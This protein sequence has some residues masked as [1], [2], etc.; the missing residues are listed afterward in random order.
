MAARDF[1]SLANDGRTNE[2]APALNED[3]DETT[4][5]SPRGSVGSTCGQNTGD[6]ISGPSSRK[7]ALR[8]DEAPS[9]ATPFEAKAT[10]SEGVKQ[11]IERKE[12]ATTKK[13][14]SDQS[15]L[16]GQGDGFHGVPEA[17]DNKE[18]KEQV[19][20]DDE[21][22]EDASGQYQLVKK[23]I[24]KPPKKGSIL[25]RLAGI[26]GGGSKAK[27][28][29]PLRD[30]DAALAARLDGPGEERD[31]CGVGTASTGGGSKLED[32][33]LD[34]LTDVDDTNS[35]I[36]VEEEEVEPIDVAIDRSLDERRADQSA[37]EARNLPSPVKSPQRQQHDQEEAHEYEEVPFNTE[38]VALQ[39]P[40]QVVIHSGE[41]DSETG[42]ATLNPVIAARRKLHGPARFATVASA[43]ASPFLVEI[44]STT[45]SGEHA[46]GSAAVA[47]SSLLVINALGASG[48]LKVEK[49]GT[50][51]T[52]LELQLCSRSPESRVFDHN[53]QPS[54]MRTCLHKKGGSE[55]Q[56]NQQFTAALESKQ[57]QFI[58]ASVKTNNRMIVGQAE[59][60]LDKVGDLFYDQHYPLYRPE[61]DV[62]DDAG[63]LSRDANHEAKLGCPAGYVHLQLK[64]VD[65]SIGQASP[66]AVP[67][68]HL[69]FPTA[70]EPLAA[71]LALQN[72]SG[73]GI[74]PRDL[75]NG[76]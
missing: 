55:A 49:F 68:L 26:A 39:E 9:N 65:T 44:P 47:P 24:Y 59:V 2:V 35:A 20:E 75:A 34:D 3:A 19:D 71:S 16:K 12:A 43:D 6:R 63:L 37:Q 50:Q 11:T 22:E 5:S 1:D 45:S 56:W 30:L 36:L 58:R 17:Q 61:E 31:G 54:V 53:S 8:E 46:N 25:Q 23:S 15:E 74:I 21:E 28:A 13:V 48:L 10:S 66:A 4:Q 67:R 18:P 70:S 73:K 60:P 14:A 69:P 41:S 62:T 51:S 52:L 57:E 33:D 40:P 76:S 32:V 72:S 42:F 7:Y 38:A 27:Y 64:I 29:I